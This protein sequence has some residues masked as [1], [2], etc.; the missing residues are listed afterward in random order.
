MPSRTVVSSVLSHIPINLKSTCFEHCMKVKNEPETC[1]Q[2]CL[3]WLHD[4]VFSFRH[5]LE[6]QLGYVSKA[7]FTGRCQ[8]VSCLCDGKWDGHPVHGSQRG[9][10]HLY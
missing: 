9:T 8:D 10:S 6:T 3:H 2:I 1:C 5:Y 7:L 4:D